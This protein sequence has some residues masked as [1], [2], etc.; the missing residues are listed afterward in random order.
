MF[1]TLTALLIA[2]GIIVVLFSL[3]FLYVPPVS[4]LMMARVMTLQK[5]IY[6]PVSLRKISPDLVRMVI[7]A[8][9]SQF[10]NHYGIDWKSLGQTIEDAVSDDGPVRGAS[11][12]PMQVTKNLFLWP[13][14]SYL[15]KTIELPLALYLNTL[16]PKKRML[17]VYL[18]VAEWGKGIYGAEAAAQIYF[19]KSANKLS[20]KESSLLAASLPSPLRRNPAHPS[21]AHSRYA[22]ILQKSLNEDMDLSCIR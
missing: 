18:S 13:Q 4:T 22:A 6:Q 3:L 20:Q 17:E 9:D 5:V 15:R 10:C 11:T 19:H 21:A 12:I 7:R 2:Y 14:H 1:E 8:E 16:W